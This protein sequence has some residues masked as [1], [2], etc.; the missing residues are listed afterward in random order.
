MPKFFIDHPVF[1]WVVAILI[2]LGGML[3]IRNLGVESYPS[4]APPQVVVSATYPGGSASTTERA[5][6]QVIEQQLSGID[7]LLFFTSSSSAGGESSITLTFKPGTDPD[8]AQ[9]QVQNKVALA[10]PRLPAEAVQQGIVVAKSNAAFLMVVGMRADDPKV[11]LAALNDLIAS[12]ILDQIARLPGVGSV[13][14]FGGEYAMNIWLDPDKLHGYGL[15]ATQVLAALRAQNVQFAAGA[16]G[17]DP[18]VP[19]QGFQ[20][21]VTAEGSFDSVQQFRDVVLRANPDGTTVRLGD[22]ARVEFGASGYGFSARYNGTTAAGF[23]V[24]LSAGANALAVA[25]AVKAKMAQLQPGFPQGIHWFPAYDTSTFVQASIEEVVKTLFEALALVF[26]VML[27]FLQ[28][29][30]ATVIATLV[31]PVALLGTFLGM[32]A[33]GFTVNQLTLFG[34]VLAIGIVVDD[35]IVVIENVERIMSEEHLPPRLATIKAM[36]QITGAVVAIAVVLA[37][38]FIPSALQSGSAGEIYKQF[39]LTIAIAMALSAFLA[40]GFTPALCASLLKVEHPH[41]RNPLFRW[42]NATFEWLRHT[43]LGHVGRAVRHAP[44]WLTAFVVLTVLCG[45]L[46][47]KLPS[48]FLPDEDQGSVLVLAQLPPGASIQRTEAVMAQVRQVIAADPAVEGMFDVAG[49]SFIGSS[50]NAGMAFVRLKNWSKRSITAAQFIEK[51]NGRL[52][53]IRDGTIFVINQATVSGLGRFGGFDMF[54]QDRSGAGEAALQQAT[55]QLLAAAAKD[56]ALVGVRPNGLPPAPELQLTVDRT[57][58]QSMGLSVGDIYSAIGLMLAPVYVNDFFYQGRIKRV[59]MQADAPFRMGPDA[60]R[61]IYTPSAKANPAVPGDGMIPLADVVHASWTQNA[62]TLTRYN[63]YSAM[64]IVGSQA[65]GHS[66]GEAMQKMQDIVD[67]QLPKGFGYDWAGQSYQEILSGAQG[68]MLLALSILVVFLC[69]AALYESWSVP[70]AVLAIVPLGV[71]GAV[72]AAMARGLPD[73]IFFKVGLITIIGLAAKNA[74]LIVEFAIA[75][76][77][78]GRSLREAVMGAA[79]LRLRP[80]LMTSFAF[81][82]GVTPMAISSGA[83][84][85]ARHALGTGV[86]GGMLFATFLGLLLIPVFYVV[87]RRLLGDRLDGAA[88]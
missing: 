59:I 15:S 7:N 9:V 36:Q 30:R 16:I 37:A 61:Y 10:T 68:P 27:V 24:Q 43:Y 26:L 82:M 69:L 76:Q 49:F 46:F 29:L 53:G 11:T 72:V 62:P 19:G 81:I 88:G 25:D 57:Q 8:T 4:I 48:S 51:M 86:I 58:A 64:E 41:A 75:E 67:Q 74:I 28:N 70:V 77:K 38:V 5:V 2:A 60:L 3:A 31:I 13:R 87:V 80:I 79:R 50:E 6:T 17:A 52:F 34:M 83:G 65:P 55:G 42:F 66:S 71:L 78:A 47:V 40:L 45:W 18:A 84:A 63:G 12:R 32:W 1:A 73:D 85:N 56:K 39:A 22:V 54:L 23:A 14:Q 21:S 33:I 20:A 44:R 35:A